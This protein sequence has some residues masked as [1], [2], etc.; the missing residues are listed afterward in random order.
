M[1]INPEQ[2]NQLLNLVPYPI[3]KSQLID[4]LRQRGG[5]DQIIG[6]LERLPDVTFNSAQDVQN[7]LSGG[8]GNLGNLGGFKL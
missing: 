2:L 8:L 7:A 4:F 5:N 6:L 1:N 3:G